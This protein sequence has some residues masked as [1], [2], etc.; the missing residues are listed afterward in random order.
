MESGEK[1]AETHT[2]GCHASLQSGP[3]TA[4]EEIFLSQVEWGAQRVYK[5]WEGWQVQSEI[6]YQDCQRKA[7]T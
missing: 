1:E 7:A 6:L 3:I 4:G 5:S 2:H